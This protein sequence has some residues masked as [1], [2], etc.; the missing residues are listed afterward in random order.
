[1]D[2]E[3]SS[4]EMDRDGDGLQRYSKATTAMRE[5]IASSAVTSSQVSSA[6]EETTQ[7]KTN[8]YS[9]EKTKES[10]IEHFFL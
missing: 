7:V 5:C 6:T 10:I 9:C 8:K 2:D 4:I 3:L 1:M